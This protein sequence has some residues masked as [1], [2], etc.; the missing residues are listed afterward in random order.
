MLQH[1]N[2]PDLRGALGDY[3]NHEGTFAR[4]FHTFGGAR[5]SPANVPLPFNE[6]QIWYKAHLQ[7]KLYYDPSTLGSTF[8]IHAHLPDRTWKYGNYD[9]AVLNV[10]EAYAW[11]SSGLIAEKSMANCFLIYAECLDIVTQANGSAVEPS[12]GLHILK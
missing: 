7:Q 1:I 4:N 11:P 2:L 5:R 3:V 12:S 8:T 9:A 10:D 6:L